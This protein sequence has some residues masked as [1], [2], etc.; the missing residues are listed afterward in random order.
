MQPE[1]TGIII[2]EDDT[3][4]R[5]SLVEYLEL[6]GYRVVGVSSG[7]DF[8]RALDQA[9][10]QV[11]I[12]DIGLPDQ[13]GLVLAEYIKNNTATG[14]IILTAND[15][16]ESQLQGYQAGADNYLT[17]PVSSRLLESAIVNLLKRLHHQQADDTAAPKA[18][19]S[20]WQLQ[21]TRWNLVTPQGTAIP[22][23]SM[24]FRFLEQLATA[25]ENL[26]QRTQLLQLFYQNSDEYTGR[27]LDAMVRRLRTKINRTCA[28]TAQPIKTVYGSGF[29]FAEPLSITSLPTP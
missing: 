24:E 18:P 1:P 6:C 29:C 15:T 14:V 26:V 19:A 16:E 27:A 12:I 7:R 25:K 23:T 9:E 28:E 5:E 3:D 11:A 17:K 13:S 22:L 20:V 4:L 2:V 8:Y 10:F 21:K